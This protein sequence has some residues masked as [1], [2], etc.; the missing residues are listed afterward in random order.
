MR[1]GHTAIKF[2]GMTRAEDV[3]V[4][5]ALGVDYIGLVMA[6]GSLRCVTIAQAVELAEAA[7]SAARP[8]KVVVLV[9]DATADSVKTV[10]LAVNPDLL[11]FHGGEPES[12]CAAFNV[13]YWKAIGMASNTD[14]ETAIGTYPTADAL[15]LDAHEPGG[16]G[17]TGHIFDWNRWPRSERRLVLAGGLH[18]ANVVT[19][20]RLTQPFAVDVSTGIE[21]APGFKNPV[22]M[23]AFVEAIRSVGDPAGAT[24]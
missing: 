1:Q 22:L 21:S 3:A 19:A 9:R 2:C 7:R 20:I 11:Q 14:A 6:E 18:P 5:A 4:A 8:P 24:G 15:L 13:P 17:G 16:S 10:V 12:F 23:R